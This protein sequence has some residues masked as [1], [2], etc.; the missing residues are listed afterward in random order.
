MSTYSIYE[1]NLDTLKNKLEVIQKKCEKYNCTF[2]YQEIGE[3]YKTVTDDD[4]FSFTARFVIVD[5]EGVA[6]CESGWTIA[7]VIER[8]EGSS[9]II[10][11]INSKL[12]IPQEYYHSDLVCDHCN[13]NRKRKSTVLIYNENTQEFKQ[14]GKQCLKDYTG[15]FDTQIVAY[16][17]Q[18][19]K[20][21]DEYSSINIKASKYAG[22]YY[23]LRQ[24][25]EVAVYDVY[26]RGYHKYDPYSDEPSTRDE[27]LNCLHSDVFEIPEIA[28]NSVEVHVDDMLRYITSY[29]SD[30]NYIMNLKAVCN[31]EYV[32]EKH[33]GLAVSLVPTYQNY[34]NGSR[35]RTA[36]MSN[37]KHVGNIK[38]KITFDVQYAYMVTAIDSMYGT[39]YMYKIIDNDGNVYIWYSS[40]YYDNAD[41][42]KTLTG[43]VKDHTEYQNVKETILT[44]CK[45]TV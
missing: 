37:S 13:T 19:I 11:I 28:R 22:R 40:R 33:M 35:K 12:N 45:P 42:W 18:F 25:L 10:H 16:M 27:V 41:E 44:R 4:G 8:V 30:D 31:R 32:D 24:V 3:E 6:V 9:N 5:V 2:K 26:C 39:S 20:T 14:V 17:E 36:D 1:G 23:D 43:T 7:A 29:E 21:T 34:L 15:Y 38:D